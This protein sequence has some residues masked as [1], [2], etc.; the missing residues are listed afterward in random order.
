MIP[1][2]ELDVLLSSDDP[3]ATKPRT[4]DPTTITPIPSYWFLVIILEKNIIE[5]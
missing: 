1:K 5:R 4:N 3:Y 2:T